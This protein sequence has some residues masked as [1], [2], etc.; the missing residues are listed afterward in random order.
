MILHIHIILMHNILSLMKQ[1]FSPNVYNVFNHFEHLE[2]ILDNI[3]A[4]CVC[5]PN[6]VHMIV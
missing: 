4:T 6:S 2:I 3:P 1:V 5:V